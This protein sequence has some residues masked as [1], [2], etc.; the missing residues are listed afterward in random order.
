MKVN[1]TK[2]EYESLLIMLYV[3]DW[4]TGASEDKDRPETKRYRDLEQKFLALAGE[5]GLDNL[6]EPSDLDG[7]LFPSLQIEDAAMTFMDDF[8]ETSLWENLSLKLAQRDVIR[9]YGKAAFDAMSP[10]E[11][12]SKVDEL[13][14]RYQ[15]EF[16]QYGSENIVVSGL[17]TGDCVTLVRDDR[18]KDR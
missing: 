5:F 13:A 4:V 8:E 1:L 7:E 15:D 6:V 10:E 9:Q 3:A 2:H 17:N 11:R 16:G 12:F 14:E 18:Q